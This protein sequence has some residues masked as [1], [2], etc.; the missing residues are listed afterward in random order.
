MRI[1]PEMIAAYQGIIGRQVITQ[2]HRLDN[3][4]EVDEPMLSNGEQEWLWK[5]ISH[6]E[7]TFG[8][9]WGQCIAKIGKFNER[10][11]SRMAVSPHDGPTGVGAYCKTHRSRAARMN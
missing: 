1:A 5:A 4:Q 9:V 2:K 6:T 3:G 8:L 7:L 11:C 10:Y